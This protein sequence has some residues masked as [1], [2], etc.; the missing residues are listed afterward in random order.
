MSITYWETWATIGTCYRSLLASGFGD[1]K[2]LP[3]LTQE[4]FERIL[5]HTAA[6]K[7]EKEG[8]DRL[9]DHCGCRVFSHEVVELRLGMEKSGVTT[10]YSENMT[11]AEVKQ[12]QELFYALIV[13]RSYL[14]QR[15]IQS[16]NNRLFKRADGSFEL[17]L[18]SSQLLPEETVEYQGLRIHVFAM[19]SCHLDHYG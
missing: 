7:E 13:I 11:K 8:M 2:I 16:Y 19:V 12:I 15:G 17:R 14:D 4:E 6:Y 18:A 5:R 3:R 10:Y 9:W 1:T